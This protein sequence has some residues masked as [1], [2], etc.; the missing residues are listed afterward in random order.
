MKN[1]ARAGFIAIVALFLINVGPSF[2]QCI[3]NCPAGDGGVVG[4]GSGNKSPDL[5]GDAAVNLVDL[6]LFAGAWPPNPYNFCM[7][8][9]CDGLINLPDLSLFAIHWLHVGNKPGFCQPGL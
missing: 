8:Y 6:A 7:D 5:D 9:N 4:P 2:G 3:L 1:L